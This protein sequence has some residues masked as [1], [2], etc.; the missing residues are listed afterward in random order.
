MDD[1]EASFLHLIGGCDPRTC[2]VCG[3]G[4]PAE[5]EA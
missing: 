4:E 3:E 5:P 1:L 2:P